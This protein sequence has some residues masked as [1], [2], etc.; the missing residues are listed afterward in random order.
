MVSSMGSDKRLAADR[1]AQIGKGT[2]IRLI[3]TSTVQT[4]PNCSRF[5]P[6]RPLNKAL[7]LAHL[8]TVPVL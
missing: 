8:F 6:A 4:G 7:E 3:C 2:L 5:T 1:Q